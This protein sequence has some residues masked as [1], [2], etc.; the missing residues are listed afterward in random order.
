MEIE[1][2]SRRNNLRINGI[3]ESEHET[4]E[5][6][7]LKVLKLFEE[8]LETKD[9]KIERAHRT[10]PRGENKNRTIILKLLNYKDKTDFMMRSVKLKGMN[11]YI[12]EDFYFK[13]VQIRKDLKNEMFKQREMGK[14]AFIS[15][16]KLIVREWS[17]KKIDAKDCQV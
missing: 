14:H 15:Y 16:D 7:E 6:S 8:T 13:T 3:K 17:E 9:V 4:W 5:E 2:R 10:V 12:N 1:D 11:I